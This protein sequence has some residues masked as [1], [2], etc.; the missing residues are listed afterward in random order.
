MYRYFLYV[1][2]QKRE[3]CAPRRLKN[4]SNQ[5]FV[6]KMSSQRKCKAGKHNPPS[7]QKTAV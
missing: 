3:I 4:N 1:I 2:K 6:T 7:Q 5:D